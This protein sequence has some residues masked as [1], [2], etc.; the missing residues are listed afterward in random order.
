ME[1]P[2]GHQNAHS[3]IE[4]LEESWLGKH[5][6]LLKNAWVYEPLLHFNQ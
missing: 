2:I 3:I 1:P 6:P 4:N 5:F